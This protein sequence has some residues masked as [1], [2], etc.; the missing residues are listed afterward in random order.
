MQLPL[1]LHNPSSVDIP[2][3]STQSRVRR[4]RT[5]DLFSGIGGIRLGF[6]RHNFQT[7]FSNDFEPSCKITSDLNFSAPQMTL[8]DITQILPESLPE[9]DLLLG[10]FPCQAFSVAGYRQGFSDQKGRG[11]LFFTIAH[12][13]EELQPTAFFLENVKNLQGHDR[14]RTFQIILETLKQLGYSVRFEVLNTMKHGNLPQNRERI[15]IVGF[16]DALQA[17]SFEFPPQVDLKLK[18]QDLLDDSVPDRYY[19]DGK[20][21]YPRLVNAVNS[22]ETV[23][24]WRRKYVRENKQQVCPTLTANMGTGGHNVPIILDNKGIRKLTPREC[25][26][27][28]GFPDSYQLPPIA[29]SLLYKQIGNSVS[30]SVV[31]AIAHEIRRVLE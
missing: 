23:Y 29:D 25:A 24:Q 19:Y 20:P 16:R 13:L 6:E 8:G 17:A 22:K 12:I 9:F 28:Q 27:F 30:V 11:N 4:Y 31:E 2:T 26:R 3:S 10:G 15:Y 18:V 1:N 5:L 14:G 21:L 7:V